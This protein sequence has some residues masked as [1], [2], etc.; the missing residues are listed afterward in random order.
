MIDILNT[1]LDKV[2]SQLFLIPTVIIALK[3]ERG[4]NIQ[5]VIHL[6]INGNFASGGKK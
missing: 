6:L 2:S 4:K 3:R 5:L 1:F